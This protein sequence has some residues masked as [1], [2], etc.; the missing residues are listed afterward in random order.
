MATLAGMSC[1]PSGIL[2]RNFLVPRILFC[3]NR[4]SSEMSREKLEKI[5]QRVEGEVSRMFCNFFLQ[6]LLQ[7]NGIS[8][9]LMSRLKASRLGKNLN[10]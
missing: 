4:N 2:A 9:D 8:Y 6:T 10:S 7:T 3:A 1:K 5:Q